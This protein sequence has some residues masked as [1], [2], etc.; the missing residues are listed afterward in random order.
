MAMR[1]I[2]LGFKQDKLVELGLSMDETLILKHIEDFI[3]SG[4]TETIY[5]E[6]EKILYHWIYYE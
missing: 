5:D 3:N 2:I 6:K 4:K 1:K